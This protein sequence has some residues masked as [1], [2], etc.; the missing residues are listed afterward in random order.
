M[1]GRDGVSKGRGG[2]GGVSDSE[3]TILNNSGMGGTSGTVSTSLPSLNPAARRDS[4]LF[5][6]LKTLE[7]EAKLIRLESFLV[8]VGSALEKLGVGESTEA[9][10]RRERGCLGGEDGG[11]GSVWGG[12]VTGKGGSHVDEGMGGEGS[13][14]GAALVLGIG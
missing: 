2:A 13:V 3:F 8:G 11:G 7:R 5:L 1:D 9:D 4:R 10:R 14:E 12:A 6:D